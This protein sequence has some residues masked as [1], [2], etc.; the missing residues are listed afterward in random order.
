[1]WSLVEWITGGCGCGGL[2]LDKVG[3]SDGVSV[4]VSLEFG[5]HTNDKTDSLWVRYGD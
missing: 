3:F 5:L 2:F 4:L 1:M